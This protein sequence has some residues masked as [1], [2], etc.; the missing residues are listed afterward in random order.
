M[1]LKTTKRILNDLVQAGVLEETHFV[2]ENEWERNNHTVQQRIE[3]YRRW[4]VKEF[5]LAES[6]SEES[7]SRSAKIGDRARRAFPS[8]MDD[9]SFN[10]P[11]ITA[12]KLR[13]SGEE[14]LQ[15]LDVIEKK[16]GRA[17][18]RIRRIHQ[19]LRSSAERG[20]RQTGTIY[21]VPDDAGNVIE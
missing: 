12:D 11:V 9:D 14:V 5:N 15:E 7:N 2:S 17:P 13:K 21:I 4:V 20:L 19:N 1:D 8:I 3:D 6:T 18:P 10:E 16:I